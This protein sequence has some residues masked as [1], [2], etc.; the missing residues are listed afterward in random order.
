MKA[1]IVYKSQTGFTERYAKWLAERL[2]GKHT[3]EST[4]EK[5]MEVE[6]LTLGDA[7]KLPEEHFEAADVIV[8]GG[9]AMAGHISGGEWF[10]GHLEGWK[11]RKL[12]M[13]CT[14]GSPADSPDI[15]E[16][17][18]KILTAEQLTYAGLFYCPGGIA[19]EKMKTWSRLAM[20]SFAA[21]FR[22]TRN[23]TEADRMAGEMMAHSYDIS[24]EK[25]LDPI[26]AYIRA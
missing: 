4:A 17:F 13:F 25:Y 12:A 3:A 18:S 8:Y 24:D 11:G 9:W 5:S 20:K 7:K 1:I 14:G 22:K 19:Y 21:V 15:K 26:E 2:S 10:I 6:L 16:A 23:K